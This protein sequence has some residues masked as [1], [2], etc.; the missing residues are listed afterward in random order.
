LATS[1][2][3]RSFCIILVLFLF[4]FSHVATC[5][6]DWGQMTPRPLQAAAINC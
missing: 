6:D 2:G 1:E 4:L 5:K 3:E